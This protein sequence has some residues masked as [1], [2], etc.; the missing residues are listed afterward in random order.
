MQPRLKQG[1][2]C[3]H[4]PGSVRFISKAGRE[5]KKFAAC[6]GA[7][8]S[9]RWNHDATALVTAGEDGTVKVWSRSG[10]LRSPI[11]TS[12]AFGAAVAGTRLASSRTLCV[13]LCASR[14]P[15]DSQAR[16][17]GVLGCQQ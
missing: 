1:C 10:M 5:E 12:G 11:A 9:L 15:A 16:L 3:S 4:A 6:T 17:L 7:A 13:G 2:C 14:R 8:I